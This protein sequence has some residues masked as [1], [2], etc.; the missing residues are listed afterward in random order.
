MMALLTNSALEFQPLTSADWN[1]GA[2]ML[3]V[4]AGILLAILAEVL[5]GF[6]PARHVAFLVSLCAAVLFEMRILGAPQ[7]TIFQ[8]TFSADR[9][10]ALWGILFCF[11]GLLAWLYSRRYYREEKS[12]LAEHDILMLCSVLGMMLMAGAEDLLTFFVGLELLSVPLYSLACFR[13]IRMESVEAGL[14][15]FLLGAFAAGLF[16]F[17]TALVYVS[18]GSISLA[19]I[20]EAGLT[21]N[22]ALLGAALLASALFFKVS[23]FPFQFWVPD[24]YQGSP[25]PVTVFMATGT[26]AAAFAFLMKVVFLLP[27]S[28]AGL[29]SVM[30]IAT[31]AIGNLGALIQE[32]LKRMLGYSSVAHAGTLLLVVTASLV[33]DPQAGAPLQAALYY[34][35]AYVFTAAGAFGLIAMLEGSGEH[36]TK[37]ESLRGLGTRRPMLAGALSLFM[38]SLGGFP[39]TGG[40]FGKYFVFSS[41][42]RADMTT[43]AVLGVLLS[44]VAL[45]YYLRVIMTMWMR[46]EIEGQAPPS[47]YRPAAN[48]ATG[49]CVFFVLALGFAPGWFLERFF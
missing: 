17:G 32:D 43:A 33:G 19:G 3:C 14:R 42:L 28:A 39:A 41:T 40:F 20:R 12:F 37:L 48:F 4:T 8:G 45:G 36:F 24:V 49:L 31:M 21:D 35:A 22:M 46:P 5:P 27:P 47:A 34:M 2:P 18:T 25:T 1:G 26:K 44:V 30:A 11:S 13:R 7:G 15:Y 16:L 10:S 9:A 38:L 29:L 23:V 6:K